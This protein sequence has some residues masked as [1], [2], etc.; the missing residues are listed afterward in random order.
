M[1]VYRLAE[2][3]RV[4]I[5][6]DNSRHLPNG[7]CVPPLRQALDVDHLDSSLQQCHDTGMNR[8]ILQM[9]KLRHREVTKVPSVTQPEVGEAGTLPGLRE[10]ITALC[11]TASN[12]V[13]RWNKRHRCL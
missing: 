13:H 10:G 11:T 12:C 2:L 1:M 6:N 9:R 7:Y 8:A 4:I 5:C 3:D